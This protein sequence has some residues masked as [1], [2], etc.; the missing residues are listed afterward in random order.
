MIENNKG[1][2]SAIYDQNVVA[3]K[4][5]VLCTNFDAIEVKT[6]FPHN[7]HEIMQETMRIKPCKKNGKNIT[8]VGSARG[9]TFVQ[10]TLIGKIK[11]YSDVS[12]DTNV[13]AHDKNLRQ[14]YFNPIEHDTSFPH[15][16]LEAMQEALRSKSGILQPTR[17]K[18][19]EYDQNELTQNT[20]LVPLVLDPME[21]DVT[22]HQDEIEV[23]QD[24]RRSKTEK[25]RVTF[26]H[27]RVEGSSRFIFETLRFLSA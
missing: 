11:G 16:D 20:N 12:S 17:L 21:N 19:T 22:L 7:D 9:S 1:L 4:T 14:P 25:L 15:E 5:N 13:P 18:K 10:R 27:N 8:S 2:N 26:Y 3:Q 23:M 6:F 24:T